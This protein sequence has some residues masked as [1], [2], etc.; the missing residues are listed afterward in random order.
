MNDIR[1]LRKFT[2]KMKQLEKIETKIMIYKIKYIA[3]HKEIS[4][5]WEEFQGDELVKELEF[6]E[7]DKK[8]PEYNL[9]F[10]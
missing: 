3:T 8:L 2:K 9:G 6:K 1:K 7:L 10:I 4:K 5:L